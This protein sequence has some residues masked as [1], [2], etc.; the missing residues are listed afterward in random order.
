MPLRM[1][2]ASLPRAGP[3]SEVAAV[4]RVSERSRNRLGAGTARE[5]AFVQAK[6]DEDFSR[7]FAGMGLETSETDRWAVDPDCAEVPSELLSGGKWHS[8]FHDRW[9]YSGPTLLLEARVLEKAVER[10]VSGQRGRSC[11]ALFL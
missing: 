3:P 8:V 2:G 9:S 5:H 6:F 10:F 7:D 1:G 11:H 4:G